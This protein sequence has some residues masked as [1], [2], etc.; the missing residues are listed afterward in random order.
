MSASKRQAEPTWVKNFAKK[1]SKR[2]CIGYRRKRKSKAAKKHVEEEI[3]EQQKIN[4]KLKYF[5]QVQEAHNYIRQG[6]VLNKR[7]CAMLL[8]ATANQFR[9]ALNRDPDK[10]LSEKTSHFEKNKVYDTIANYLGISRNRVKKTWE[11]FNDNYKKVSSEEEGDVLD[12]MRKAT[13][14]PKEDLAKQRKKT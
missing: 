7:E 5:E 13:P 12:K 4:E 9:L 1:R 3:S 11:A 2:R 6:A 14:N 10:F 8:R